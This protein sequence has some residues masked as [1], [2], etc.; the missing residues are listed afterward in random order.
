M[1]PWH[2]PDDLV[3]IRLVRVVLHDGVQ[4]HGPR[5]QFVQQR[6]EFVSEPLDVAVEVVAEHD[7]GSVPL[8]FLRDDSGV[9]DDTTELDETTDLGR[10]LGL[11]AERLERVAHR[12]VEPRCGRRQ[13]GV[14]DEQDPVTEH[15]VADRARDRLRRRLRGRHV[16]CGTVDGGGG[17]VTR[18][19]SGSGNPPSATVSGT[20]SIATSSVG[21][22]EAHDDAASTTC[23][24]DHEPRVFRGAALYMHGH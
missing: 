7:R 18:E 8:G 10:D 4:E 12:A 19:L 13:H 23:H 16:D 11:P 22:S 9:D 15:L 20:S 21:P 3:Q 5:V 17:I 24:D 6:V 14:A 1:E 2:V